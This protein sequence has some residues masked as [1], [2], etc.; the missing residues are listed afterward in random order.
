MAK[1]QS[2]HNQETANIDMYESFAIQLKIRTEALGFI[3]KR[4]TYL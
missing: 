1:L 2:G 3:D 4:Q